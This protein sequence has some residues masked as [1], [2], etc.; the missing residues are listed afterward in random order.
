MMWM[1]MT[2]NRAIHCQMGLGISQALPPLRKTNFSINKV[3]LSNARFTLRKLKLIAT[4]I[5]CLFALIAFFQNLIKVMKLYQHR[6]DT[7]KRVI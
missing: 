3:Q 1:L 2:F 6:K 7:S 5:R 4:M